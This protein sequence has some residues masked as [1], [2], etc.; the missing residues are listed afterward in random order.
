MVGPRAELAEY[1]ACSRRGNLPSAHYAVALP[2]RLVHAL[3]AVPGGKEEVSKAHA[4]LFYGLPV[5]FGDILHLRP[6]A[7][8][9]IAFVAAVAK[10]KLVLVVAVMAELTVLKGM[11][12]N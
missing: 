8:R 2:R 9:V 6:K 7:V 10:Q 4:T 12:R 1:Q 11:S 3:V 5:A